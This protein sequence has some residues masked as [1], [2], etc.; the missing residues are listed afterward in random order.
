MR[1]AFGREK[2]FDRD[3]QGDGDFSLEFADRWRIPE[4]TMLK[5]GNHSRTDIDGSG[6]FALRNALEYPRHC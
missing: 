6:E 4:K 3:R 5:P 2:R 1:I